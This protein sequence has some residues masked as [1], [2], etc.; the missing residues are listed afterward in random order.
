M[1]MC[2]IYGKRKINK[3]KR[4]LR[5]KLLWGC[6]PNANYSEKETVPKFLRSRIGTDPVVLMPAGFEY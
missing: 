5:L 3:G 2:L 6:T 1:F 4:S